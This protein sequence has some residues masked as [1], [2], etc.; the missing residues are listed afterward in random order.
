LKFTPP[1]LQEI[2]L[3][4]RNIIFS[5]APDAAEVVRWGGLSYFH[6]GRGGI[7]SAGICQIGI[8]EDHIRLAFIHGAFLPD[9]R[10]LLR[11][12][13][14]AKRFIELNS[15]DNAPWD[16]LKQLI[17]ASSLFDPRSLAQQ[18]KINAH[19]EES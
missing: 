1:H 17:T 12:T 7:V 8:H 9:P 3:E 6:D 18:E 19:K 4:L 2:V 13:Q 10:K 5:V 16:D 15:Y 11:G 14:K